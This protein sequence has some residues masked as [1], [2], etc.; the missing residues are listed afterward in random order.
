[1][2]F[3]ERFKGKMTKIGKEGI[4][5]VIG[6]ESAPVTKSSSTYYSEHTA[7]KSNSVL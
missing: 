6:G 7:Y 1:M 4:H 2:S 3:L 5:D